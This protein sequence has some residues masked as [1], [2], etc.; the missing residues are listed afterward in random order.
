MICHS[1]GTIGPAPEVNFVYGGDLE[2]LFCNN[3]ATFQPLFQNS[4]IK[5]P[6]YSK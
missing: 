5:P 6:P 3:V 1:K 2:L 4:K